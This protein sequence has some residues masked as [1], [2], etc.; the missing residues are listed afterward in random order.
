MRLNC[1]SCGKVCSNEVP[2]DTILRGTI[3]CP[4][5]TA[6]EPD[7]DTIDTAPRDGTLVLLYNK[8]WRDQD[9]GMFHPDLLGGVWYLIRGLN[10]VEPTHWKPIGNLPR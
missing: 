7:W 10:P 6:K 9:I 3:T 4:E 1:F 5:C 2:D 8:R